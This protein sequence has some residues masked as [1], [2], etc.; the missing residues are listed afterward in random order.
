MRIFTSLAVLGLL[1][2]LAT[3]SEAARRPGL[4][5]GVSA[6]AQAKLEALADATAKQ[7]A[8]LVFQRDRRLRDEIEAVVGGARAKFDEALLRNRAGQAYRRQ[9]QALCDR[10]AAALREAKSEAEAAA[11]P[12]ALFAAQTNLAEA[13]RPAIAAA[14]RAAALDENELRNGI[15][16]VLGKHGR[17]RYRFGSNGTVSAQHAEGQP[18]SPAEPDLFEFAPAYSEEDTYTLQIGITTT[19]VATVD[20]DEGS[21][22]VR[23]SP[24]IAGQAVARAAVAE[25][26]TVSEGHTRLRVTARTTVD[27]GY[28]GVA[29]GGAGGSQG[30]QTI[31]LYG[32][33]GEVQREEFL[34]GSVVAPVVYFIIENVDGPF[35]RSATFDVS[36]TGGEYLVKVGGEAN[37]WAGGLAGGSARTETIN[38]IVTVEL[39]D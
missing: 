34:L 31:E 2:T 12:A 19:P 22:S 20:L 4:R 23:V 7:S 28:G 6:A 16:G 10:F 32:L 29:C 38:E 21:T 9:H 39:L 33:D 25:Y 13:N 17:F 27:A 3:T 11:L 14:W 8:E 18:P 5:R 15:I 24:G 30:H 36:N 35:I 37:A 1:A 26:L